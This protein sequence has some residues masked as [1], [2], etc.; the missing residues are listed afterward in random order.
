MLKEDVKAL[1]C[2]SCKQIKSRKTGT[3]LVAINCGRSDHGEG[4]KPIVRSAFNILSKCC[5]LEHYVKL[6]HLIFNSE[7][8]MLCKVRL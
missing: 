4:S 5:S 8:I 1:K 6:F 3:D 2:I 7:I